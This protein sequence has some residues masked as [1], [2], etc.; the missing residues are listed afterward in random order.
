[1]VIRIESLSVENLRC[2]VGEHQLNLGESDEASI[3]VVFGYNGTGKTT[4]ADSIRL[5]LTG[6]FEDEAPLVTYELVD[7]LSPGEEVSAKVSTVI[8]DTDI[9]RR[10]RFS[11]EFQTSETRR[12][13][14]N[15]VDSLQVEEEVDGDWVSVSSS[16]AVNTVFPL[17]AFTFC[18]LHSES[19]IGIDNPWGGISWSE[20][21]E[22]IGKAA[23]QQSAAR[24]ADLPEYFSNNYDLGDEILRRINDL[25]E[26]IDGRYRVEERQDGLVGRSAENGSGGEVHSLPTGE[27]IMISHTA[28]VVAGEMMPATPPLIGDSIFGRVDRKLRNDLVNVIQEM[29]RHV[30]LFAIEPELEGLDI[31]P[32]F[33]LEQNPEDMSSQIV[34]LE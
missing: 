9:G 7:Q 28:S 18:K 5:C 32:R 11:R 3:D 33:K 1:M 19:S 22:D 17:P 26:S 4:L 29:D 30:L 27:Q 20:L 8:S 6:E 31:E 21:V 16:E 23:A 15:S 14:V 12:G 24:G 2:F 10:F 25:L 34:T 13:P